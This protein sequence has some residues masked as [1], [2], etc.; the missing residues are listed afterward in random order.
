MLNTVQL[1]I[2]KLNKIN[3]NNKNNKKYSENR[4]TVK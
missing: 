3:K 1:F 2:N 4:K